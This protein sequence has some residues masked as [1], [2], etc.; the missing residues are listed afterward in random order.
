MANRNRPFQ[1]KFDVSAEE[2][3]LIDK[4]QEQTG[5]KNKGAFYRKMIIDGYVINTD[6]SAIKDVTIAINRIGNNIN[7]IARRTNQTGNIYKEDLQE[8]NEKIGDIWLLL[9]S[10]LSNQL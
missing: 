2:K 6:V 9:K 10:T 3:E 1:I 8:I 5:I 4:K 7:Q